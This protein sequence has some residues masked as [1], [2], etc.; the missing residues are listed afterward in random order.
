MIGPPASAQDEPDSPQATIVRPTDRLAWR[1]P[2]TVAGVEAYVFLAYVDDQPVYLDDAACG[3]SAD[4]IAAYDC[5]ASMP[6]LTPG[7]HRIEVSALNSGP[8]RLESERSDA[9]FVEPVTSNASTPITGSI[10]D[11]SPAAPLRVVAGGL[12]DPVDISVIGAGLVA[13]AERRGR[14]LGVLVDQHGSRAD[15]W[16]SSI[17][18][19][20]DLLS[21]AAVDAK[22]LFAVYAGRESAALVRYVLSPRG[23][24]DRSVVLEG[25]PMRNHGAAVLRQGPDGMLYLALPADSSASETLGD[26]G[27]WRGKVLRLNPNG[28]LPHDAPSIAFAPSAYEPRDIVWRGSEPWMLAASETGDVTLAPLQPNWNG[29]VKSS[30]GAIAL[31]QVLHSA[32]SVVTTGG[33]DFLVSGTTAPITLRVA[34]RDGRVSASGNKPGL[35]QIIRRAHDQD[36]VFICTPTTLVIHPQDPP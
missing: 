12:E 23:L 27:T 22:Y 6:P 3:P 15:A 33:G 10:G 19:G 1:Q 11:V 30:G 29:P 13:V 20:D 21:I 9:I 7:R 35:E 14:I 36:R 28:S 26:V 8:D 34:L 2:V 24:T 17:D 16:T 32:R 31:P 18:R 5:T 25:L 4:D